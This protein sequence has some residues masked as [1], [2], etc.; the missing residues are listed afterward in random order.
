MK[1]EYKIYIPHVCQ[2]CN[3]ARLIP[4]DDLHDHPEIICTECGGVM[5]RWVTHKEAPQPRFTD[6]TFDYLTYTQKL[7]ETTGS[8]WDANSGASL[9]DV[10]KKVGQDLVD[11]PGMPEMVYLKS[12]VDAAELRAEL[13]AEK[14]EDI[15]V[16]LVCRI[17]YPKYGPP[18]TLHIESLR[19][20]QVV[21]RVH[22][23]K[24]KITDGGTVK[25]LIV[26]SEETK[27]VF[28]CN[29]LEIDEKPRLPRYGQEYDKIRK[30]FRS[31]VDGVIR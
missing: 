19:Y 31:T 14:I 5:R 6:E 3:T 26:Y 29:D 23:L 4:R 1:I 13:M 18:G 20:S 17:V 22:E 2:Y 8:P 10:R 27:Q 7:K 15:V 11:Y 21:G 30:A 9:D 25:V 28:G 24:E 12:E 16:T